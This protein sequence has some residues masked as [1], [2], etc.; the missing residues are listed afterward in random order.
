MKTSL[1]VEQVQDD[2]EKRVVVGFF[3][4][5]YEFERKIKKYLESNNLE[6]LSEE[7]LY[8]L[9]RHAKTEDREDNYEIR[10]VTQN[11]ILIKDY[12]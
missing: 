3:S 7:D 5:L 9:Q 6:P 1:L 4:S 11:Q 8:N 10:V 2:F 12:E